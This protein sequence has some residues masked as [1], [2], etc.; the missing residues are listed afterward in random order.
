VTETTSSRFSSAARPLASALSE[1]SADETSAAI[2]AHANR[3]RAAL[4]AFLA[5]SAK[6]TSQQV[7]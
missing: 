6:P 3:V 1:G 2:T 7:A 4:A 5:E